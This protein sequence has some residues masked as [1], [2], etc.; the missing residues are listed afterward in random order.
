MA[1]TKVR[2]IAV[3]SGKRGGYGAMR[4]MMREIC[5][6]A[7]NKLQLIVTDQHLDEKFGRT[8]TEI[9]SD[10]KISGR[11]PMNQKGDMDSER[12]TALG[13]CLVGMAKTLDKLEPDILVLFGDRGESLVGAMA[14]INMG[15]PV[16]HIQGGDVSGNVDD[17]MRNAITKLAHFHFVSNEQSAHRLT[18]L[19]ENVDYIF[20]VGDC[21]VDSIVNNEYTDE[22]EIREKFCIQSD[23]KF[24]IVL[25]HPETMSGRDNYSDMKGTINA[26]T[27]IFEK[28]LIIYPCSDQGYD[29]IVRAINEY[30]SDQNVAIYRN[31]EASDFLGLLSIASLLIGNSSAGIIESPYFSLPVVNL[32][33]RQY[34]RLHSENVIH[35]GF[36]EQAISKAIEVIQT[37]T[38][39]AKGLERLTLHYG[40]GGA[41]KKI[42]KILSTIDLSKNILNK[43][44][45]TTR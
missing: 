22:D 29:G 42:A 39:F 21:H 25:Q 44:H 20:N 37:S 27:S 15:I 45:G 43:H 14:A 32:G 8:E 3:L 1:P 41:G 38:S 2:K 33:E 24:S 36:G 7:D 18:K 26:V 23:Q 17:L 6:H 5:R 40:S 28:S 11:I 10:F 13:V 12:V 9:E 34:G 16:G 31:I 4:P 30:S 19:G 35:T